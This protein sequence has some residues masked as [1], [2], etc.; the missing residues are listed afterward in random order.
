MRLEADLQMRDTLLAGL[1][2]RTA[3]IR[4]AEAGAGSRLNHGRVAMPRDRV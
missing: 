3:S 2:H 1:I 4:L